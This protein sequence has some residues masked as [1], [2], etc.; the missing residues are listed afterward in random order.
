MLVTDPLVLFYPLAPL[1][2]QQDPLPL[3][4]NH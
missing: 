4:Q 2:K 1:G 3:I